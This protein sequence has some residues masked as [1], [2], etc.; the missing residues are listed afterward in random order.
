MS[1]AD[2]RGT[3]V[4]GGLGDEGALALQVMGRSLAGGSAGP[5]VAGP[6]VDAPGRLFGRWLG[7]LRGRMLQGRVGNLLPLLRARRVRDGGMG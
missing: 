7:A 4:G 3:L 5:D 6:G 1:A 2:F